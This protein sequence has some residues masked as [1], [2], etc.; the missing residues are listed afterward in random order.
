MPQRPA[1][2][3]ALFAGEPFEAGKILTLAE[4]AAN[5]LRVVIANILS[6]VILELLPVM[7]DALTLDGEAILSGI[8]LEEREMV[9]EKLAGAGW[10]V[11]SEESEGEWWSAV[12]VVNP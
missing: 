10:L 9:L 3:I 8:L 12:A 1:P 7:R 4:D 11:T 5:H 6:S 2:R